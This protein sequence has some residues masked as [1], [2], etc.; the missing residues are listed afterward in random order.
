MK[1]T[2]ITLVT[3]LFSI[4]SHAAMMR[5]DFTGTISNGSF[6]GALIAD[7]DTG[8][9]SDFYA[10]VSYSNGTTQRYGILPDYD[11]VEVV[12]DGVATQYWSDGTINQYTG[13]YS[14][15]FGVSRYERDQNGQLSVVP[16][17]DWAMYLDITGS[18]WIYTDNETS[19]V[20]CG[21]GYCWEQTSS[22]LLNGQ[23]NSVTTSPVPIPPAYALFVSGIA[24]LFG[25]L[26]RNA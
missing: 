13:S 19:V 2:I 4:S 17:P 9:V 10:D 7:W 3:L 22:F 14:F 23:L 15:D 26:K 18:R 8:F 21:S 5:T 16:S 6:T 12:Q 20:P 25:F 24:G 1:L 11:M